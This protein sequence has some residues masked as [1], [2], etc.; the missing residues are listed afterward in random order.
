MRRNEEAERLVKQEEIWT[1]ENRLAKEEQVAS[2][3]TTIEALEKIYKHFYSYRDFP[4]GKFN[5]KP[6]WLCEGEYKNEDKEKSKK[7]VVGILKLCKKEHILINSPAIANLI[8][9]NRLNKRE[10]IVS[11]QKQK[12]DNAHTVQEGNNG[13]VADN[14]AINVVATAPNVISDSDDD[15][16]ATIRKTFSRE[17]KQEG[18]K[19]RSDHDQRRSE[20]IYKQQS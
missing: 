13:Y 9:V 1:K 6:V 10:A 7:E 16:E 18:R 15:Y 8:Y 19:Q 11:A 3:T 14:A 2:W 20:R 17:A 4:K 5:P 12:E